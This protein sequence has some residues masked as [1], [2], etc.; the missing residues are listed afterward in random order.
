MS[1]QHTPEPSLDNEEPPIK[2]LNADEN[3]EE[4]I[5]NLERAN[6]WIS[7][8][9]TKISFALA[10]AGILVGGFFASSII[11][12]SLSD[13]VEKLLTL[14]EI[15]NITHVLYIIFTTLVL[16]AFVVLS[17]SSVTF[18]F[19]ALKGSINPVIYKQEGLNTDSTIFFG[20]IQNKTFIDFKSSID[21][22]NKEVLL[23]D[24]LSQTY[25]NSKIAKRK[26]DLYNKGILFLIYSTL[27]FVIVNVVFMFF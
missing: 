23:N 9:D 18:L 21:N 12:D 20:T 25:I 27:A 16:S 8:C 6:F 2:K 1:D 24:Y 17:V 3:L 26:F 7:N 15:G 10:F 13:L 22:Q 14:N 5:R 11:T 4:S 19:L